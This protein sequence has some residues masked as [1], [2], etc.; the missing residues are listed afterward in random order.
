M[1]ISQHR[2]ID[3]VMTAKI[4]SKGCV[5]IV[6]HNLKDLSTNES[7][8]EEIRKR[9]VAAIKLVPVN[10][11]IEIREIGRTADI[12]DDRYG[13]GKASSYYAEN[14]VDKKGG[15]VFTGSKD[16]TDIVSAHTVVRQ[17]HVDQMVKEV[18]SFAKKNDHEFDEKVVRDMIGRRLRRVTRELSQ[19]NTDT[20]RPIQME[21]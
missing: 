7:A 5:D 20:N 1:K 17:A 8:Q 13:K 14:L 15:F 16:A 6:R 3:A 18:E 11:P 19:I 2:F 4:E 12:T 10:Q 21:F 9:R